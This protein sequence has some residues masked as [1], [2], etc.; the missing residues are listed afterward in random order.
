[1]LLNAGSEFE[2]RYFLWRDVVSA[3]AQRTIEGFGWIGYW[4]GD[5]PP[6]A[7][8]R[9]FSGPHQSAL[10]AYLDVLLQLGIVGLFSFIALVGLA[11]VR[12]WL[13]GANRR[14]INFVWLALITLLLVIVSAAESFALV[15]FGWLTLVICILKA[16]QDL[17]W[18]ARLGDR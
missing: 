5:I 12:S 18:R 15:E 4:R 2:F 7:A 17:S 6:F 16:S 3:S 1:L 14:S 10:N 9:T 11:L 8:L 13:L